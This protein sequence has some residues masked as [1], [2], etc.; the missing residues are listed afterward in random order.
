MEVPYEC[1]ETP[2]DYSDVS[3]CG[4]IWID[5]NFQVQTYESGGN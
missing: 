3:M 1:T 2:V 4:G 5:L